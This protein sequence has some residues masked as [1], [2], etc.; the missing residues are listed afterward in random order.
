MDKMSINLFGSDLSEVSLPNI[1]EKDV[2]DSKKLYSADI[3]DAILGE[4]VETLII[5]KETSI[6]PENIVIDFSEIGSIST[7]QRDVIKSLV[8][9]EG[10]TEIYLYKKNS[11]VSIGVGDK[12]YMERVVPIIKDAIFNNEVRIYKNY[13]PGKPIYEITGRD[14]TKMR[15]NF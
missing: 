8:N 11:L 6:N 2:E 13:Q 12:Y 10:H 9:E 1:S 7:I 14:F 3:S 4:Q 15:M 5:P